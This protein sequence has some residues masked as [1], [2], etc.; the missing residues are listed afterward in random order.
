MG[1]CWLCAVRGVSGHDDMCVSVGS[2]LGSCRWARL[3][4]DV[5][6]ERVAH[7]LYLLNRI[8]SNTVAFRCVATWVVW[9]GLFCKHKRLMNTLWNRVIVQ[10]GVMVSDGRCCDQ[11]AY[12]VWSRSSFD[13]HMAVSVH[14][15]WSGCHGH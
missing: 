9:A 10:L 3:S 6:L 8:V 4:G 2:S 15:R 14:Y 1:L 7:A 13:S 5:C 11:L 12:P